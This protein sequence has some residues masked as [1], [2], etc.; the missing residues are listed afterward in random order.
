MSSH[1]GGVE[2]LDVS[3][4]DKVRRQ[5]SFTDEKLRITEEFEREDPIPEELMGMLE[6]YSGDGKGRVTVGAEVSSNIEFGFKASAFVSIGVTCDSSME[7]IEAVHGIVR[8]VVNRLVQK[9]HA[10][11]S[12]MRDALLPPDKRLATQMESLPPVEKKAPP[13][14]AV[15]TKPKARRPLLKRGKE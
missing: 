15:T 11:V 13:S 8:P 2:L 9:D 10:Q 4:R 3:M 12:D 14:K 1:P 7:A 6:E 5:C